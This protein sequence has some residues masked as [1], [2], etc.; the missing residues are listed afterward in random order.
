MPEVRIEIRQGRSASEKKELLEAV[1][2]AL[3][4]T[5]KIPEH[6]RLQR[7]Y[8]HPADNFEVPPEKTEMFTLIEI[9]MFPGRSIEAKR[10]LYRAIVRN[11]G[12]LGIGP[13]DV[14]ITLQ[15]PAMANWGIRGGRPASEVDLGFGVNI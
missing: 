2:S 12:G 5:L 9:T 14:F 8:E 7:L 10:C 4:E 11:L 15:E 6:D 1:H 13:D 3:V